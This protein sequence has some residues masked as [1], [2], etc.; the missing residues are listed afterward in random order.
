MYRVKVSVSRIHTVRG[1]RVN[2]FWRHRWK[3]MQS[4][5]HNAMNLI[6]NTDSQLSTL[7]EFQIWSRRLQFHANLQ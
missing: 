1:R 7:F 3:N 4:N 5:C 2:A 6:M